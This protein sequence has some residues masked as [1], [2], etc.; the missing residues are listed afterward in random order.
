MLISWIVTLDVLKSVYYAV[1]DTFFYCWIVTLDV[2]KYHIKFA[3][4]EELAVE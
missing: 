4:A 1:V 3:S 2:L